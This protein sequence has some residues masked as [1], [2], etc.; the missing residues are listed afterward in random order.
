MKLR[1]DIKCTSKQSFEVHFPPTQIAPTPTSTPSLA[2]SPPL[3]FNVKKYLGNRQWTLLPRLQSFSA[4]LY[5]QLLK[6]RR[7]QTRVWRLPTLSTTDRD[8]MLGALLH[9][10]CVYGMPYL[11]LSEEMRTHSILKGFNDFFPH[12]ACIEHKHCL[13]FGFIALH[14]PD[15]VKLLLSPK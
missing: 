6:L 14:H 11:N 8:S 1:S 3:R 13:I 12:R 15:L 10:H 9:N 2:A 7:I 5:L 4:S